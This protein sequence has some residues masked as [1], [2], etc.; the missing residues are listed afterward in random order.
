MDGFSG[1]QFFY[2][3]ALCILCGVKRP[4]FDL[5]SCLWTDAHRRKD[6]R[7]KVGNGYR[8][9]NCQTRALW[10]GFAIEK[11]IVDPTPKHRHGGAPP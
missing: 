3:H 9:L 11:A 2:C 1:K 10:S 4:A 8:I 7:M 5:E 6:A